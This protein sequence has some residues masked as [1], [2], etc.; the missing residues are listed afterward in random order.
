MR[1]ASVPAAVLLALLLVP[2]SAGA[3]DSVQW[4]GFALVRPETPASG[5]PLDDDS[6]SAQL[7]AGIDWRPSPTFGTHLHLLA[8]NESDGSRRGRVG[9]VE[10]FLEQNIQTR[11]G[12]LHLMEGAFFLPTSRENIDSLWETPYT[13]T[14]SA[15]NS[16]LGEEL[17]PVGV[18]ASYAHRLHHAGL[19]NGTV[20]GGATLF[21]GN[22]T[23]G[24]L[25][26]DR[27]WALRDHWA[28]LGEHLP[29][30]ATGTLFTSVSAENDDRLGWS[31]RAKWNNDHATL[32]LTHI[33]NRSDALRYGELFNWA[34]RYNIVGAD[35]TWHHWTAVGE[36]SWGTT[37]IQPARGRFSFD[38]RASYLLLSRQFSDFRASV[39]AD[40]YESGAD[41]GHAF[42]AAFFWEPPH[43]K[44]RTG[45]EGITADGE[46]RAALE[47]RYRF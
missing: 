44:L 40:Q 13:I 8:R 42:T 35:Y 30:N 1:S 36:T 9:I 45:L 25:P 11:G 6:F 3:A 15:L 37:A 41:H 38:L 2:V 10:A 33:D 19:L 5:V 47:F 27:G 46:K 17:R 29:V 32:Q 12:R 28:L 34:T 21:T 39:R 31:A 16:W 14:S 7:Q 18:D 24:A 4:N 20:I 43:G 23:F 22:D 26:I